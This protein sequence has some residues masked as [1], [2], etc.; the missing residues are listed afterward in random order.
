L[1]RRAHAKINLH[2]DVGARR[3]DGYH[4][5]RTIFQEISLHDTLR[6]SRAK[7]DI[8]F[9]CSEET[10]SGSDNLIVTA[11]SMLRGELNTDA[12]ARVHLTKRIPVGAGLGGGSSDA[13]AA[14]MAGLE[15][16]APPALLRNKKKC[17]ELLFPLAKKLGAD[18]PFFLFGGT[19]KASGIGDELT[20]LP[21]QPK[22]WL[23][24][25]Y[26]RVH[27]STPLA[28]QLLDRQ[29]KPSPPAA[30]PFNSFEAVVVPAFPPVGAAKQ[31]L[32]DEGCAGV[33]MSGSGSSV[34]GFVRNAAHAQ[35]IRRALAKKKW[36]VFVVHTL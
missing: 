35:K 21:P 34:F 5:L 23:V 12:G 10:L 32:I 20:P 16:W 17:A 2:L 25:A 18:V 27:V 29:K 26:P 6:L 1:I 3:A 31:S 36:D 33:L 14:L 22:R 11:L 8:S 24:L 28:Y 19:A 9:T 15:L 4:A 13:A 7:R 30:P